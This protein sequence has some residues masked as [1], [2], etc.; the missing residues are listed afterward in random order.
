MRRCWT[1]RDALH[2]VVRQQSVHQINALH[3]HVDTHMNVF[4]FDS[5]AFKRSPTFSD[6][7]ESTLRRLLY[8]YRAVSNEI[9]D[10]LGSKDM[11]GQI[12]SFGRPSN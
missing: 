7:S 12:W 2:W 8:E 5:F 4:V 9:M 3:T 6:M 11:P 1:Y 10:I